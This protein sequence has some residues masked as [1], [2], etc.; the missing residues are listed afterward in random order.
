M[1]THTHTHAH[2]QHHALRLWCPLWWLWKAPN[3]S[4]ALFS[5][6]SLLFHVVS[7]FNCPLRGNSARNINN[8][9]DARFVPRKWRGRKGH[10]QT[11]PL[12]SL[13]ILSLFSL[14]SLSFSSSSSS[15]ISSTH[16]YTCR[17]RH[18]GDGDWAHLGSAACR[19]GG[20]SRAATAPVAGCHHPDCALLKGRTRQGKGRR[21][22]PPQCEAKLPWREG[23]LSAWLRVY[24]LG[25]SLAVNWLVTMPAPFSFVTLSYDAHL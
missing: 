20:S 25:H 14:L 3:P 24:A 11:Q 17:H 19:R 7:N 21:R 2:T 12:G 6:L 10:I 5:L 23:G 22:R 1:T 8:H 18:K 13:V 15:G 9:P 16:T 4:L